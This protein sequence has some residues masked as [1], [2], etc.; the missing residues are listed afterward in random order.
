M[1][2]LAQVGQN[3]KWGLYGFKQKIGRE[4][5]WVKTKMGRWAFIVCICGKWAEGPSRD[6][7]TWRARHYYSLYQIVNENYIRLEPISLF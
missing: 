3:A 5:L 1:A 2:H 6:R 7:Q 4:P